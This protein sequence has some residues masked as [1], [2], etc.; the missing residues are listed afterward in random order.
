MSLLLVSLYCFI[1]SVGTCSLGGT[2]GIW[3]VSCLRHTGYFNP[4]MATTLFLEVEGQTSVASWTQNA[5]IQVLN[6]HL[7]ISVFVPPFFFVGQT[8][9]GK[10]T[11]INTI[12]ASHLIDS[13]G[14]LQ[15]D[16]PVRQTTEIQAASH[17]ESRSFLY[18]LFWVWLWFFVAWGCKGACLCFSPLP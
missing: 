5:H 16:E 11:L 17:G 14:R 3:A 10:S 1:F 12:F 13:K 18:C 15:S 8:G 9:L 2:G 4:H 6:D 7:L